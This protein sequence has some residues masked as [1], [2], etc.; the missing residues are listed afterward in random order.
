M[1]KNAKTT[2]TVVLVAAA[3]LAGAFLL[4]RPAAPTP[5]PVPAA[6]PVAPAVAPELLVREDSNRLSVSR[7]GAVTLVEFLDFECEACGAAFP[8]L[9][10]LRAEY[11]DRITFVARYFPIPSHR[12]AEN[13]AVAVQAAAEQGQFEAMYRK[14]FETQPIW[15]EQ[16]ESKASVFRGY[17]EELGLNLTA[18]DQAVADPATLERVLRDRADGEAAGVKGTPTLYLNGALLEARSLDEIRARIDA[19]LGR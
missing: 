16:D 11:G 4:M 10:Q 3:V 19:E 14:M 7:D 8:A 13:A 17:A 12:N 1:T 5:P 9:E 6:G 2:L 15:A 18:Y